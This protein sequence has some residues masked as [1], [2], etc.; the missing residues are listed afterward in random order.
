MRVT[1]TDGR[2][3][4][5]ATVPPPATTEPTQTPDWCD[6]VVAWRQW[7]EGLCGGHNAEATRR[8]ADP[9]Q[10]RV[11]RAT[12]EVLTLRQMASPPAMEGEGMGQRV[13]R[14]MGRTRS[15]NS[16]WHAAPVG[17]GGRSSED[18]DGPGPPIPTWQEQ[19]ERSGVDDPAGGPWPGHGRAAAGPAAHAAAESTVLTLLSI[20]PIRD[21]DPMTG[22]A[23]ARPAGESPQG[24]SCCS[25][26]AHTALTCC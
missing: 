17:S 19:L 15:A 1:G 8:G 25:A 6:A 24:F 4:T 9:C 12:A 16:G 22:R 20:P 3:A 13:A 11:E 21:N 5:T 18:Q 10:P 26:T 14:W 7:Q 2:E 23:D